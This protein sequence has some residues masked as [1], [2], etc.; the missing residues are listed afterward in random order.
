MIA[1]SENCRGEYFSKVPPSAHAAPP[2]HTA[3]NMDICVNKNKKSYP[4]P[5]PVLPPT[6]KNKIKKSKQMS[7]AAS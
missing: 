2:L 5:S 1:K 7:S 6:S 3:A 4:E